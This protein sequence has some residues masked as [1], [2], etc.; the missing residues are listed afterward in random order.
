M[1]QSKREDEELEQ[2]RRKRPAVNPQQLQQKLSVLVGRPLDERDMSRI[3][4][5]FPNITADDTDIM[6]PGSP[7]MGPYQGPQLAP[8]DTCCQQKLPRHTDCAHLTA[9]MR[10]TWIPGSLAAPAPLLLL[11]LHKVL[12][13]IPAKKTSPRP[14]CC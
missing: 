1:L 4:P 10:D 12:P 8:L 5:T 14:E 2:N 11:L 3:F 6:L 9:D 7:C 13:N